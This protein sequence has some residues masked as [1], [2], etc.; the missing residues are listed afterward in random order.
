MTRRSIFTLTA[1][2]ACAAAASAQDTGAARTIVV[3]GEALIMVPPDEVV[4]TLGIE[5]FNSSLQK[6]QELSTAA[7]KKVLD[8]VR[9]LGVSESSIKT[10]DLTV[11]IQYVNG[12]HPSRGIEGYTLRRMYVVTLK[13]AQKVAA[14][15]NAALMN[16]ANLLYGIDYRTTELRKYRD[17]ARI[18]AVRAAREKATAL[19]AELGCRIGK[20]QNISEVSLGYYGYRGNLPTQNAMSSVEGNAVSDDQDVGVVPVGQIGI[21]ATVQV[22]FDI[23]T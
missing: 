12:D 4:V 21:R 14:L 23:V 18:A 16:G 22:I 3:T 8:A 5:T 9:A 1:L 15:V 20:P 19:T 11:W 6:A 7:G 17:A 13:D 2:I 10:D